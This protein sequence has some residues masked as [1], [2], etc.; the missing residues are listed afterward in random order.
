M[1]FIKNI[2]FF[3]FLIFIGLLDCAL[4]SMIMT[5][6]R[7]IGISPIAFLGARVVLCTII[8]FFI[9]YK[10]KHLESMLLGLFTVILFFLFSIIGLLTMIFIFDIATRF[11]TPKAL[12]YHIDKQEEK[13]SDNRETILSEEQIL[14]NFDDLHEL[15]PLADGMTDD[16]TLMRIAAISAIE[17]TDST[18][19]FNILIDSKQDKS[20]EVQYFAHEALKK[21]GDKYMKKINNLTFSIN[22]GGPGPDYQTLKELADLYA[23]LAHKNIEHPILVRFYRQEAI[24]YYLGLLNNYQQYHQ[25]ILASLI[26][27]LYENG[28]Y[29]ACIK[30]CDELCDTEYFPKSIEYKARCYFELRDIRSLKQLVQ[31]ETNSNFN[32]LNNFI[33]FHKD[34][35]SNG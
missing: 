7:N 18:K 17:E 2:V 4:W 26:T 27:V 11:N 29:S 30:Y 10:I 28:D 33:E 16:D 1:F 22:N 20:K 15:S 14:I 24:R 12:L 9:R 34:S 13:G 8:F 35:V 31:I 5:H 19:L 21:I 6:P 25:S 23:V 32:S 3:V